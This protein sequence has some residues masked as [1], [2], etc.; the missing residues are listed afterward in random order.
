VR[1]PSGGPSSYDGAM[2]TSSKKRNG[3]LLSS[4]LG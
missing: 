1:T 2:A 3:F 4:G